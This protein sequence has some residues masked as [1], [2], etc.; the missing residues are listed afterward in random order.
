MQ[1]KKKKKRKK[2]KKKEKERIEDISS[3]FLS[4]ATFNII[5]NNFNYIFNCFFI[6]S[7]IY[8]STI[9]ISYRILYETIGKQNQKKE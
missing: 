5:K 1:K 3:Y 7:L 8:I 9:S 6:Q 4:L 2:K